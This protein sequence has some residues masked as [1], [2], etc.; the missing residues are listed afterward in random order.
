MAKEKMFLNQLYKNRKQKRLSTLFCS[1]D[2]V[3]RNLGLC[4]AAS[5]WLLSKAVFAGQ[6]SSNA[7][8]F[9]TSFCRVSI[10]A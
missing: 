7:C 8:L 6:F 10:F 9:F 1:R 4:F 3:L 2:D 5:C